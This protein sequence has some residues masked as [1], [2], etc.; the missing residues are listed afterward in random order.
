MLSLPLTR[1]VSFYLPAKGIL[2]PNSADDPLPYYHH[3]CVGFLYRGRI[4][5]ALSLLTP[6]YG[7]ILEIGYGSGILLPTLASF[8]KTISGIDIVSDPLRVTY[9]LKKIGIHAS[10]TRGDICNAY[11][12][13]ESFD[14]V[15]AISI[16]EHIRNIKQVI[17]K[18]FYLLKPS[19]HFL[20]GIASAG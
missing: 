17:D 13:S 3:P 15:V 11:Y 5:Q 6:P 4:K 10:L 19:G 2:E 9:N 8:G 1:K 12:S 18:V 14:L 20:V 16:L 7:S